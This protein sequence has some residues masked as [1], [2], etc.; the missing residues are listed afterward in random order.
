MATLLAEYIGL[1]GTLP[2]SGASQDA[3]SVVRIF[4]QC[5][6]HIFR[7]ETLS[8]RTSAGSYINRPIITSSYRLPACESPEHRPPSSLIC[9][10]S[11]LFRRRIHPSRISSDNP[12]CL[13]SSG[14]CT[15]LSS[16]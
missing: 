1:S 13:S 8:S 16:A 3:N 11:G 4:G 9:T 12:A 10:S 15:P 2:N 5:G 6:V 14:L 7:L